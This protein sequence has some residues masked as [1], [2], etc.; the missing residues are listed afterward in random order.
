[1]PMQPG[2]AQGLGS[3]GPAGASTVFG[4]TPPRSGVD[5]P[6]EGP[7]MS[8]VDQAL[9]MGEDAGQV[10]LG[11]GQVSQAV[12]DATQRTDIPTA[13]LSPGLT[14]AGDAAKNLADMDL[15]TQRNTMNKWMREQLGLTKE[16]KAGEAGMQSDL[17]KLLYARN[18]AGDKAA[19]RAYLSGLAGGSFKTASDQRQ[20][21]RD[22][23]MEQGIAGVREIQGQKRA[24]RT[25]GREAN[26][27]AA[28]AAGKAYEK[29]ADMK[30]AG[31]SALSTIGAAD[32]GRLNQNALNIANMKEGNVKRMWETAV[33]NTTAKLKVAVGNA[34][35]DIATAQQTIQVRIE[36]LK[37]K[38]ATRASQEK[39]L[40][41]INKNM[42]TARTKLTEIYQEAKDKINV[43]AEEGRKQAEA[44]DA[45]MNKQIHIQLKE[46][47]R[48]RRA[49]MASLG[50]L[51][52]TK[53]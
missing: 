3:S 26:K 17:A 14:K 7:K 18:Q 25:I 33:H 28:A 51:S 34:A 31:V 39:L 21:V 11:T 38:G 50:Q 20:A 22:K 48:H 23:Q 49:V 41:D 24:F 30:K 4:V 37:A 8:P 29:T 43:G 19:N 32:Q 53:K 42:T 15:K 9:K 6:A 10:S 45:E 1:M 13:A 35:A 40:A 16:D 36:Q 47:S 5:V 52:V 12:V 44:L 2:I 27:E 46:M